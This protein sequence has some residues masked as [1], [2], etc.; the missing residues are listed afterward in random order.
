MAAATHRRAPVVAADSGAVLL[1]GSRLVDSSD[2][3]DD[4]KRRKERKDRKISAILHTG[5]PIRYWD[6]ELGDVALYK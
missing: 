4:T 3:D 6:H 5:M 1:S 2:A